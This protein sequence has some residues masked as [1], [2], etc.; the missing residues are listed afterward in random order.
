MLLLSFLFWSLLWAPVCPLCV[1]VSP[2][3]SPVCVCVPTCV[4]PVCVCVSPVCVSPVCVPLYPPAPCH[5][6]AG[7]LVSFLNESCARAEVADMEL[8]RSRGRSPGITAGAAPPAPPASAGEGE[9]PFNP[10]WHGVPRQKQAA[11]PQHPPDA[12]SV[13]ATSLKL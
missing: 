2:C 13:A 5:V 7:D 12:V 3:V 6:Q 8:Q 1:C 10:L 4:P 9:V 11:A